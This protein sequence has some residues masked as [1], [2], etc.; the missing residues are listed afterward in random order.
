ME[1]LRPPFPWFGG[2]SRVSGEIWRR[3]GDVPNYVE[4]FAGSIAVLLNRPHNPR[5]ETINDIDCFVANFWRA[6][7]YAPEELAY[8]ADYPVNE[9]DLHARHLW[10]LGQA[11]FRERMKFDPDFYDC[12]IAGW[13]VWGICQWIGSG[14]CE[15]KRYYDSELEGC[16]VQP[17]KARPYL[18]DSGMGIHRPSQK[19][20]HLGNSGRGNV[21]EYMQVL[22][23]R[24]RS[25]RVVCGD[26]TRVLGDSVTI[27]HGLTGIVLDPPYSHDIRD[28]S[29][30]AHD[31]DI[32]GDVRQWAIE[33]GRCPELRIAL[34][35]YADEHAMPDDW[36]VYQWKA[37]G[38]YGSQGN[39]Q[40]RENASKEVIW[41]SPHCIKPEG[42]LPLFSLV[43][44]DS[45]RVD[46]ELSVLEE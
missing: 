33:H 43:G 36:S 15:S 40:G 9:A 38:G 37:R 24:L 30:Y 17:W 32:A 10:L 42:E 4:P 3:L 35:G 27:K 46:D 28:E 44:F 21:Y 14:W 45:Q 23:N 11:D 13:W 39:G 31:N 2:K 20:P 18:G 16:Q 12:K 41:F 5:T 22:S 19:L 6:L 29:L 7:R 26:W 8:H 1:L 34:C 25:V